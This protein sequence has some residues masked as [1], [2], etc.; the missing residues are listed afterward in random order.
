MSLREEC[1]LAWEEGEQSLPACAGMRHE[2][3]RGQDALHRRAAQAGCAR[4][5]AATPRTSG[6]GSELGHA[7]EHV[8]H[9]GLGDALGGSGTRSIVKSGK[10]LIDKPSYPFVDRAR[11]NMKSLGDGRRIEARCR[12]EDDRCS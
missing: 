8:G 5:H 11:L 4:E 1:A 7:F 2:V 12:S 6:L 9:V 3:M 10:A